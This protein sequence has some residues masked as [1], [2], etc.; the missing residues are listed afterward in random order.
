MSS[1]N[2]QDSEDISGKRDRQ[3]ASTFFSGLITRKGLSANQ[4]PTRTEDYYE[5]K[6]FYFICS[7]LVKHGDKDTL[8]SPVT[9][10][11]ILEQ[12]GK[13]QNAGTFIQ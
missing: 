9:A 12:R 10:K 2:L 4:I 7:W 3:Y 5:K 11:L 6:L 13:I 8:T 1:R